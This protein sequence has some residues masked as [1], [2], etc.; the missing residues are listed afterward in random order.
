MVKNEVYYLI[1]VPFT[2]KPELDR[3]KDIRC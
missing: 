1:Q 2:G 3:K